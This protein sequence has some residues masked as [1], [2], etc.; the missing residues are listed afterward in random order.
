MLVD[1]CSLAFCSLSLFSWQLI[2]YRD[3]VFLYKLVLADHTHLRAIKLKRWTKEQAKLDWQ[4]K[5]L[6]RCALFLFLTRT[7]SC[8]VIAES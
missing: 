4:L 1:P 5:G 3:N 2:Y 7:A 8:R 6:H